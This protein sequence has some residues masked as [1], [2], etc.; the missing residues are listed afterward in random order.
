MKNKLSMPDVIPPVVAK[1]VSDEELRK[2]LD[3]HCE[4]A[5]LRMTE[6][7]KD[8]KKNIHDIHELY[9]MELAEIGRLCD[10]VDLFSKAMKQRLANKVLEGYLGW[11]DPKSE[12]SSTLSCKANMDMFD[13]DAHYTNIQQLEKEKLLKL[14]VDVSN[15]LM[16]LWFREREVEPKYDVPNPN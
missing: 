14:M 1:T 11:D 7:L 10:A 3:N 4:R 2:T 5:R 13:V 12:G 15:R 8:K 9:D 6:L 16:M